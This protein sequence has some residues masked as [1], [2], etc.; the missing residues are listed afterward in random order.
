LDLVIGGT[1]VRS[2]YY[3]LVLERSQKD[4]WHLV[5]LDPKKIRAKKMDASMAEQTTGGLEAPLTW[6]RNEDSLQKLEITLIPDESDLK[7]ARLVIRWGKHRLSAPIE[8]SF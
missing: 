4:Q 6:E 1:E 3:Y 7:K 5:L 2:G 8:V